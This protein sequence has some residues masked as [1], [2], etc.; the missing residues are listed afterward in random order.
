MQTYFPLVLSSFPSFFPPLALP[1]HM[2]WVAAHMG[3]RLVVSGFL[4]SYVTFCSVVCICSLH[5]ASTEVR[6]KT[7]WV[8]YQVPVVLDASGSGF[9]GLASI[10]HFCLLPDRPENEQRVALMSFPSEGWTRAV[11]LWSTTP[12]A[13]AL[14]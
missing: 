9:C 5:S 11:S 2:T 8:S 1:H 14:C 10:L 12:Q 6:V 13:K 7:T 4:C 3:E